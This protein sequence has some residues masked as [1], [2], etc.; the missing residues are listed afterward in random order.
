MK[1]IWPVSHQTCFN[2]SWS[3]NKHAPFTDYASQQLS[4]STFQVYD[5]N[6]APR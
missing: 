3:Q 4:S 2:M 6:M 1:G 5:E